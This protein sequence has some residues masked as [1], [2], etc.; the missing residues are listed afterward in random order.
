MA[1]VNNIRLIGERFSEARILEKVISTLPERYGVKISSLKDSRDLTSI[2][3]IKLINVLYTQEQRRAS[4]LEEYQECAFQAKTKPASSNSAYKGKKTWRDKPKLDAS[5][6]R[7]QPCRHCKKLGHPEAN[8]WFRQD[9]Q[10]Q[11]CKKIGHVEKVCKSKGKTRQVAQD[12]ITNR[13]LLNSGCTNHITPD[14]AIFKSLDRSC[15]TKVKIGNGHFI[16]V[17][18]PEI[19]RNLL[20]IAQLLEKGYSIVFKG[21]ECQISDPSGSV[22]MSVTMVDKSFVVDWNKALNSAYTA[23]LDEFKL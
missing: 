11:Y 2:S 12:N 5:R 19:D 7:D 1:E 14:A 21:K 17:E 16:K 13:W 4:R 20:S 9:V 22:L 23:S 8:C 18:V 6:R 15:K 3:L 10:C